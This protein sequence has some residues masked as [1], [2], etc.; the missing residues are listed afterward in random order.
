[1][2]GATR[3]QATP[4]LNSSQM[5]SMEGAPVQ[6]RIPTLIVLYGFLWQGATEVLF[7]TLTLGRSTVAG[8]V[9]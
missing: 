6:V 3:L 4:L 9:M 5:R 1:M 7:E 2:T 8:T